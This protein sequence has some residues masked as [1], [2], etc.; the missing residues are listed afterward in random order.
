MYNMY[1]L[2]T[3]KYYVYTIIYVHNAHTHRDTTTECAKNNGESV[4]KCFEHL[5]GQHVKYTCTMS[6]V[7]ILYIHVLNREK[8]NQRWEL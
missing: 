7:H 2:Y 1:L 8:K 6:D 5:Q 4:Q 3:H